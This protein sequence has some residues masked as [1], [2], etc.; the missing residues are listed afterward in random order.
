M[1]WRVS[2]SDGCLSVVMP[3]YNEDATIDE[4]VSRVL[5]SRFTGEL[6]VVDD[7][8]TDGTR[9]RLSQY[10]DP[11]VRV[12]LEPENRGKGAAVRR[13]F[14]EASREFVVIQDADLEYDPADWEGLLAP[15]ARGDADVVYGVRTQ[16]GSSYRVPYY[17]HMICNRMLTL[18]SNMFTGLWLSDVATCYKAFRLEVVRSFDLQEDRFGID[19]EITAKVA[20][21]GWRI[22]ETGI[23]YTSRNYAEGKKI[24]WKDGVAVFVC[25][26]HYGISVRLRPLIQSE[27]TSRI[28]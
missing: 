28:S 25:I 2:A 8:S 14:A 16:E 21:G 24:T 15:L 7:G 20:A 4:I 18:L 17:W 27:R 13:G 10:D 22:W 3:C 1:L 6:I 5:A 19:T 11:R 23:S 9:R 12:L 26:V